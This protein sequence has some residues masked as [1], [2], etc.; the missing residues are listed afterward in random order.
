MILRLILPTRRALTAA[1]LAAVLGAGTLCAAP[2]GPRRPGAGPRPR[3]SSPSVPVPPP[4]PPGEWT[5]QAGPRPDATAPAE[6]APGPAAA[7]EP[8]APPPP[9]PLFDDRPTGSFEPITWTHAP[10]GYVVSTETYTEEACTRLLADDTLPGTARA[11]LL[12][13]RARAR[14]RMWRLD[15]ARADIEAALVLD[16]RSAPLRLVHAELLACFGQADEADSVLQAALALDPESALISRA[17]G[18]VRYQQ[19]SMQSAA[20]ALAAHLAYAATEGTA[21]GDATLPLLRAVAADDLTS[22]DVMAGPDAPWITQLTAF[23]AGRIDRVTLLDRAR[24]PRGAAPDEAACTAWFY[25]GQRSLARRDRERASL[26]LL[27]ALRTGCTAI[28]EYRLAA[29]DLIRLRTIRADSLPGRLA[30]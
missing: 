4:P 12:G 7:A 18:L 28:P 11:A 3:K 20:D 24:T 8:E 25:L 17:L 9:D 10:S 14:L 15:A 6:P 16:P 27:A 21:A 1:V 5:T 29:A 2:D 22:L 19:G 23:L 26:D 13:G 30:Q